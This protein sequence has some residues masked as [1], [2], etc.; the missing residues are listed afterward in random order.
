[1]T[2]VRFAMLASLSAFGWLASIPPVLAGSPAACETA[3]PAARIEAD[4]RFLG[5]DLLE[6]REAGTRGY[7]LAALYVVAQYR[8]IGLEPGGDDGTYLQRVPLLRGVREQQGAG[9]AIT[10]DG[11]S[12][13]LAFEADFLPAVNFTAGSATVTA[14]MVFVGQAVY[15]PELQHD[16]FA[17]I[18]VAG[19]IAVVL[20]NAPA[21]F[22][23]DERAF[24]ASGNEKLGELERR[25][26]VGAIFL[27]DPENEAKRPWARGAANWRN[28]AMRRLEPDGRA[29]D[30]FPALQ[31]R[32]NAG[33]HVAEAIF[34]GSGH[35]AEEVFARLEQGELTAFELAGEATLATAAHLD[36]LESHNVI[37]RWPGS[38]AALA[39]EHVVYTAHLDHLGIGAEIDGDSIYNGVMDNAV[40]VA[41][42]LE[43]ARLVAAG[44][45]QPARSMLFIA[46]TAEEKGLLG[47]YHFAAQ[48]TVPRE[49]LVANIN[50]DMPL[51]IGDVSD[52][53]PIGIEHSTLGAVAA[54]AVEEA[55]LVLTPD[56]WPE[57]VVFV[58]SDHYAFVRAGIP[59]IYLD[60]G[61]TL[62]DGGDGLAMVEDFLR[63]RYHLPSDD[64]E[65]PIWWPAAA[66]L[67]CVNY[68]VGLL[69]ANDPARPAWI[70]GNF[71]GEKFGR[72]ADRAAELERRLDRRQMQRPLPERVPQPEPGGELELPPEALLEPVLA[73]AANHT[74]LA[75]DALT[76]VRSR[77][78][79]WNDGSL[80]C[81]EP[82][83]HYTQALVPGWHV[84]VAAGDT[85]L[86][87][88]LG[89]RGYFKRCEVEHRIPGR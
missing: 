32:V 27:G 78:V 11:T 16:D 12:I 40:G 56:P 4:V 60:S 22:P 21:R 66:Q 25:G 14:P 30:D 76:V 2:M 29:V 28:P 23:N 70:P 1:M 68:R 79:I 37:G 52:I 45:Q 73:E 72:Q 54:Q 57:E 63:Q 71:F 51:L 39:A 62:R 49:S 10:R 31:V 81:P 55:G 26:A 61:V 46:L 41:A 19:K 85:V 84:L 20:G 9:F 64:L 15:A 35:T 33:V 24:Y 8:F 83:M 34:S 75:R 7:D 82:G 18:D 69:I 13:E 58:R 74:G 48:P 67:A 43:T 17:G 6:G 47:A 65:Q 44:K 77:H 59:A 50:I 5:D 38:D 42:M 87:Y 36:R 86:D 53:I 88:R 3:A 89:E 80:G